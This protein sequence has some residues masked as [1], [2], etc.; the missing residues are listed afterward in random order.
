ME[1]SPCIFELCKRN[2]VAM[3]QTSCGLGGGNGMAITLTL[4]A[5]EVAEHLPFPTGSSSSSSTCQKTA[6]SSGWLPAEEMARIPRLLPGSP[7]HIQWPSPTLAGTNELL[8]AAGWEPC[9]VVFGTH[10]K[11]VPL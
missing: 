9:N 4:G 5:V 11:A 6:D 3:M 1:D 10:A 7:G 8:G 2:D